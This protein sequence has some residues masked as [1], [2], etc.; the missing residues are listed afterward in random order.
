[1]LSKFVIVDVG[2]GFARP[3]LKTVHQRAGNPR[4]YAR[5][6]SLSL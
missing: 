6:D 2:A 5:N 1:M 4:P 3:F